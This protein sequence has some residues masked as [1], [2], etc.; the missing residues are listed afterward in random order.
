MP[1]NHDLH[2]DAL[3]IEITPRP[4]A[5]EREAILVAIRRLLAEPFDA[6]ETTPSAWATAGRRES[7]LGRNGGSRAGWGRGLD[8]M[9]ER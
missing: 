7:V 9:T 8:R 1:D 5:E 6:P 4:S 3:D 2:I